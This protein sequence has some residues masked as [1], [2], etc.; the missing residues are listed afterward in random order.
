MYEL[1]QDIIIMHHCSGAYYESLFCQ[2]LSFIYLYTTTLLYLLSRGFKRNYAHLAPRLFARNLIIKR[3]GVITA[4]AR[5]PVI[6]NKIN[7][8]VNRSMWGH[9]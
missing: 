3:S 7:M 8:S 5:N 4:L 1:L 6:V 9:L 2:L